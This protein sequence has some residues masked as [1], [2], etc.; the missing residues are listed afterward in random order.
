M[1]NPVKLHSLPTLRKVFN[2]HPLIV[3]RFSLLA[4]LLLVT[5]CRVVVVG[6]EGGVVSVASGS[7]CTLANSCQIEVSDTDYDES[8]TAIADPGFE[9]SHWKNGPNGLFGDTREATVNLSTA[10]F[11]GVQELL[12]FLNSDDVFYLEPVFVPEGSI[13]AISGVARYEF[14]PPKDGCDGLQ[15][16]AV[17][18]RPIRGATVEIMATD[19][20]TVLATTQTDNKGAYSIIVES[21]QHVFVRIIA[22]LKRTGSPSWD[23][24]IRNNARDTGVA[25]TVRSRYW[26]ESP[27][28]NTG[29]TIDKRKNLTAQITPLSV[30]ATQELYMRPSSPFAILD[31]IYTSMR[32]LLRADKTLHFPP[33][34]VF[35]GPRN[36]SANGDVDLGEIGGSYYQNSEI[37]LAGLERDDDDSFDSLVVAHEWMH[38]AMD[39]LGRSDNIGGG[40]G[41][42][43][44]LDMR[45]A[46]GE[47]AATALASI[48]LN[49]AQYCD[50]FWFGGRVRG[51]GSNAEHENSGPNPG[52]F[53]ETSVIKLIYDLWDTTSDGVDNQ[54]IG[55]L[56]LYNVIFNQMPDATPLA[57]LL[58]FASLLKQQPGVDATFINSL[59]SQEDVHVAGI[60]QWGDGIANPVLGSLDIVPLYTRI[61]RGETRKMCS[62]RQFD[63]S[64]ADGNK[65]SEFRFLRFELSSPATVEIVATVNGDAP[66]GGADPDLTLYS[67][68][69][70]VAVGYSGQ[71]NK[72][73][74]TSGLLPAGIY[75]VDLTDDHYYNAAAYSVPGI[76]DSFPD[77][78]CFDISLG[79]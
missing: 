78:I 20:R 12:F 75:V 63:H 11:S 76:A 35:W 34:K 7:I 30:S 26:L 36:S 9:F 69:A 72:E 21:N 40:H 44:L 70:I 74:L 25:F 24:V 1:K 16:G 73:T 39:T 47:G 33:L 15:F 22:Q 32:S 56:P 27:T 68:G 31:T 55:L 17:E 57:S 58:T 52:W 29:S 49:E 48:A 8:F 51:G 19:R 2:L 77:R 4:V 41:P 67:K 64:F 50:T 23:V 61:D 45:V 59:F 14:P 37:F 71:S 6:G 46:Y 3:F 66:A 65:L 79:Y 13:V 5:G 62:N 43:D 60:N 10:S 28:F 53:N 38:Y 54:S 18:L 42:N